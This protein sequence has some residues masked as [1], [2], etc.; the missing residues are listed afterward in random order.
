V[1]H[2]SIYGAAVTAHRHRVLVV[3][4]DTDSRDAL[5]AV[6]E[7][8]GCDAAG[9]ASSTEALASLAT[10]PVPCVILLDGQLDHASAA[11]RFREAQLAQ[12]PYAAIPIVL[13]SGTGDPGSRAR[14]LGAREFVQKPIDLDHLM[15][16][17]RASCLAPTSDAAPAAT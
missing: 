5:V 9:A 12:P 6:L 2:L 13:V 8:E 17:I 16:V 1:S 15:R 14:E 7:L 10:A 3:E 11:D 4:D